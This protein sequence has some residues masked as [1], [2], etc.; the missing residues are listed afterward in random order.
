VI[1]DVNREYARRGKH[2]VRRVDGWWH[3]A[4]KHWGDLAAVGRQIEETGV[5]K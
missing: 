4:G 2:R 3:D 1:T 5:N